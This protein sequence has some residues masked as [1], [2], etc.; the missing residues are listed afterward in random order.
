M[1]A[2]ELSRYSLRHRAI[3]SSEIRSY[4]AGSWIL[5]V[6]CCSSVRMKF[7]FSGKSPLNAWKAR[8][9]ERLKPNSDHPR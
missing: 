9:F 5:P 3:Q 1:A 8:V 7:P 6:S 4:I 2:I